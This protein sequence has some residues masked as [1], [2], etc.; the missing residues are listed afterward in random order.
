MCLQN[1]KMPNFKIGDIVETIDDVIKG[2][3]KSIEG[4]YI[5]ILSSD[6][7]P[8]RYHISELV[9]IKNEIQVSKYEIA[10]IKKAKEVPKP[11]NT[12]RIKPKD[13]TAPKMEVDLHINQ[14]V[15]NSKG[16]SNYEMLNLQLDTAKRQLDFAIRKRIQKIVFIH[17]VGAGVLKEELAT[18]FRRYDNVK[19]YDAEYQTYGLGATEVYIYQN[20]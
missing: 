12:L 17:G 14:L 8:L 20:Y 3:I 10:K 6:G 16:L 18:L 4:D 11:K 2:S 5:T 15:K 1:K 9:K 7:F 13:R 19:Y